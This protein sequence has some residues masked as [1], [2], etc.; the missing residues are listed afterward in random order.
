MDHVFLFNVVLPCSA[1][2]HISL[3]RSEIDIQIGTLAGVRTEDGR[4]L[5]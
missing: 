1:N 3:C 4:D 2:T 5:G